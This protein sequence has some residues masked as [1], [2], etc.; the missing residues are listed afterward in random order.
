MWCSTILKK[1]HKFNVL[2]VYI[3]RDH[4]VYLYDTPLCVL[5]MWGKMCN[6][7]INHLKSHPHIFH[8]NVK[9]SVL[10]MGKA[11][12]WIS[13]KQS[14]CN[15]PIKLPTYVYYFQKF[16]LMIGLINQIRYLQLMNVFFLRNHFCLNLDWIISET[17][18]ICNQLPFCR[19]IISCL[20]TWISDK[21]CQY[22]K[23]IAIIYLL[24]CDAVTFMLA[25]VSFIASWKQNSTTAL[26]TTSPWMTEN[27]QKQD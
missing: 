26:K 24:N 14:C 10:F 15:S 9:F 7:W 11:S 27:R 13:S 19:L 16:P 23:N 2:K 8:H 17:W 22:I 21:Y 4:K 1:Y 6:E 20:L 5:Q 3:Q 12:R 18:S 25:Y